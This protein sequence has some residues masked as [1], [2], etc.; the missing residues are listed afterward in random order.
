MIA[1][2][3]LDG[4]L[5]EP[6]PALSC[7]TNQ[8][9]A[10]S[11]FEV[12]TLFGPKLYFVLPQGTHSL[13]G[14]VINKKT[15]KE[16]LRCSLKYKVIVRKCPKYQLTNAKD[17][18]VKCDLDNIWG[19]KCVFSCKHGGDLSHDGAIICGDDLNWTGEEPTCP[20]KCK[21]QSAYRIHL[22]KLTNCVV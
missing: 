16:E 11:V 15:G 7:F 19:S 14:K 18:H 6:P 3:R 1:Q 17:L 20:S 22:D 2:K 21:I 13:I 8:P 4:V 10:K 9:I 5:I 12:Q